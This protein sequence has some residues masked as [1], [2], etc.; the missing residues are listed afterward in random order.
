M[1]IRN[2]VL[3]TAV[4][5][6]SLSAP[7][8]QSEDKWEK[9]GP[10]NS[11]WNNAGFIARVGYSIGGT[12]PLPVPAEIRSIKAFSP[13]GG[14]MVG[15]DFYKMFNRRWGMSA[16]WH[17]FHEGFHTKAEVKGYKMSIT[18]DG[19]T[20]S[21]YFTGTD[22][23]NTEM[24]G[25]TIPVLVTCRVSPRWNISAGP[26]FSTLFKHTFK[27]EVYDNSKGVGYLRVDTP[28]GEKVNMD[29]NN[30]ATYD[31]SDDMRDWAGG[32]ELAFDW[33]AT[34]HLNVYG[35]VDWGISDAINP[36]FDAV[37]FK[38]YPIYANI[39]VAYRY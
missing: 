3:A 35:L 26:Y 27:G 18:M 11:N 1:K 12:T 38:M 30:P 24:Y 37:A 20:M 6:V 7:A 22:V 36:D 8:Q 39:G 14:G 34:R 17:F 32:V 28:T 15:I 13:K 29:R 9:W 19:N 23:T 31:F 25:L 33:K 4:A 2:I 16:G 5:L 21:G 10:T